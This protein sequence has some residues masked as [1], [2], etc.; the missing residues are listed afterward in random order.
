VNGDHARVFAG[1]CG[2]LAPR[3]HNAGIVNPQGRPNQKHQIATHV[4]S[5]NYIDPDT[6][7]QSAI[8]HEGSWVALLASLA[9]EAFVGSDHAAADGCSEGL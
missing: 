5:E 1:L 3:G 7:Q 2:A 9:G 6:W 4:E 8:H